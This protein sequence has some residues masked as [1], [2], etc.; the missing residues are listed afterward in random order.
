MFRVRSIKN[1]F[2]T[3]CMQ[4]VA[5][6]IGVLGKEKWAVPWGTT[7]TSALTTNTPYTILSLQG[8]ADQSTEDQSRRPKD[9]TRQLIKSSTGGGNCLPSQAFDTTSALLQDVLLEDGEHGLA[10][11]VVGGSNAR[12]SA[13]GNVRVPNQRRAAVVEATGSRDERDSVTTGKKGKLGIGPD[14]DG[15][16]ASPHSKFSADRLCVDIYGSEDGIQHSDVDAWI[17]GTANR[18][19]KPERNTSHHSSLH[20]KKH[21]TGKATNAEV[22][23]TLR[24]PLWGRWRK[25]NT[26][27]GSFGATEDLMRAPG[28]RSV[29]F[30]EC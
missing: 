3:E 24:R 20:G 5:D 30:D 13:N 29:P 17:I 21:T 16:K 26:L 22:A 14:G 12:D 23:L 25:D 19:G 2:A 18:S 28:D 1:V 11:R 6:L 9:P 15:T 4:N 8:P 10:H 27:A 7:T